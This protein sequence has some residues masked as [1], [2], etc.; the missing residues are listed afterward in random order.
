MRALEYI[1]IRMQDK[2]EH[3]LMEDGNVKSNDVF[4]DDD[5]HKLASNLK[6]EKMYSD[7]LKGLLQTNVSRVCMSTTILKEVITK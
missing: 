7:G 2:Y 1:I 6:A 4:R 3:R 5:W